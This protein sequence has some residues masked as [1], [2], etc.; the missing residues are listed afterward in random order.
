ML[1]IGPWTFKNFLLICKRL[2]L[3]DQPRQVPLFHVDLWIHIYD[4]LSGFISERVAIHI[5]DFIKFFT[6]SDSNN[7]D[8][9]WRKFLR[10]KVS[11]DVREPIKRRMKIKKPS[12]DCFWVNFKYEKLPTFYFFCGIIGHAERDCEKL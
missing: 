8:G 12:G 3:E 11:I 5:G 6:E 7:F 9:A 1:K 4:L 10:I 2:G